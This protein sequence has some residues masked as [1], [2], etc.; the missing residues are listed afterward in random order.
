MGRTKAG[1][2]RLLQP[3]RHVQWLW[4]TQLGIDHA[5]SRWVVESN[6]GD[7][8]ERI[9]L[10]RDA[11]HVAKATSPARFAVPDG[12]IEAR[13]TMGQVRRARLVTPAGTVRMD[14][15]PGTAEH[16]R[17]RLAE[18]F[19]VASA[20]VA[21]VSLAVVLAAA[22]LELP[23]LVQT[24][25]HVEVVE[26]WLGWSFDSPVRLPAW[27]NVAVVVAAAAASAERG[28]RFRH[29]PGLDE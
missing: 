26:T 16:G 15:E 6:H 2:G 9:D 8:E 23:Q 1:D 5:G 11:I 17:A 24:I 21:A 12:R 29:I 7:G 19:P 13:I 3:M 28:L 25:T 27:A 18:R 10:Y 20:V 4:K 14:P 22:V